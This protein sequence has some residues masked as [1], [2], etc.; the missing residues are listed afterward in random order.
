MSILSKKA[1]IFIFIIF[2]G[3]FGSWLGGKYFDLGV[4]IR[5]DSGKSFGDYAQEI[6]EKCS[7]A[8]YKQTCYE[9]EIPKL[10]DFISMEDAFQVTRLV[11]DKDTSYQ[12]CHVLGHELSAKETAK[13]PSKWKEV[14][15]R[16]PSGLCSNGC[17]HGAFQERFRSETLSNGEI[18]ALKPDL[19]EICEPKKNWRPT[20]LEQATCYHAL[21]HLLMYI[22]GANLD[23][24]TQICGGV[25][26]KS[27]GHDWSKLCYD[28]AFMQIFQPLEDE[29]FVLVAGKQPKKEELASFCRRFDGQK[30]VACWGEGWPLYFEDLLKPSGLVN[31]CSKSLLTDPGDQDQCFMG[32]FYVM[33]A[34]FQFDLEKMTVYCNS[35]PAQWMNMCFA[36]AASRLIETDYRNIPKVIS[37]CGSIGSAEAENAC[38]WELIKY[39]TYNFHPNSHEFFQLCNGM[40]EPWKSQCLKGNN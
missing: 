17:I 14:I 10:M 1:V 12:Y 26:K 9:E 15:P 11:Q 36:N 34:Q 35:L 25:S 23:K 28:G 19:A 29:D 38:Y 40:P 32:L 13:D 5:R 24:S 6:V 16:C 31:F 27:D 3:V 39:S 8:S 20:S 2:A 37:F 22:S 7:T 4:F 18:D 21:G 33:T 30:K